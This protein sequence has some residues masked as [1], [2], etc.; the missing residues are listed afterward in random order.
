MHIS[1]ESLHM[2]IKDHWMFWE[3][4]HPEYSGH[5]QTLDIGVYKSKKNLIAY[6]IDATIRQKKQ[7][8]N[9]TLVVNE[10]GSLISDDCDCA[11]FSTG[12]HGC[13]H[14]IAVARAFNELNIDVT[15]LPIH[16]D[17]ESYRQERIREE[18][19]RRMIQQLESN[20]RQAF[21]ITNQ[22]E[23]LKLDRMFS[24]AQTNLYLYVIQKNDTYEGATISLKIGNGQKAYVVKNISTLIRAFQDEATMTF[25]K[26]NVFRLSQDALNEDGKKILDF[27]SRFALVQNWQRNIE[28]NA[29]TIDMY[30]NLL[31]S[32]DPAYYT[33]GLVQEY[34]RFPLSIHKDDGY[35]TIEV[36]EE[37]LESHCDYIYGKNFIY[38][39]YSD[40]IVQEVYDAYGQVS[41]F[42]RAL[43]QEYR[44]TIKEDKFV[45]FYNKTLEPIKEY[46]MFD[47][48]FDLESLAPVISN[49]RVY[50]DLDD[51]QVVIWGRYDQDGEK[52]S[53]FDQT[54]I[55][56]ISMIEKIIEHYA[57][58]VNR[59]EHIAT[60]RTKNQSLMDFLDHGIS[61]IQQESDVF[62]SEDLKKL[63]IRK[64]LNLVVGTRMKNDLLE[65]NIESSVSRDELMAILMA[66][67]KKKN[68][69][70]LKNGEIID[71]SEDSL[72][73]LDRVTEQFNLHKNDLLKEEIEKPAY[74]VLHT[75]NEDGYKKDVTVDEYI[76]H[77]LQ[78]KENRSFELPEKFTSILRPYQIQGVKWMKELKNL[79]LNG[80]LADDM[81]L[82]KT[83]QV[84]CLLECFAKKDKSSIIVCPSSLMF[85]WMSEI[86]KFDID[87]LAICVN[88]NQTQRKE[89]IQ[90]DCDLYITTYD[91]L[92]RDIDVYKKKKFE[93]IIIDEAQF[94][95]N[96]KTQNAKSVKELKGEHKL[97]LTGTPI[98]N[99][100]S[101]L[102]SIFDFLLPG[103]LYSLT[104]FTKNY[105]RPIQLEQA[106]E[107]EERLRQLVL[108]FILR[109]DKN[110]VLSELPDKVEKELWL[111]FN[112][113]EEKLYLANLTQVNEQLAQQLE[114][115][116]VDS[117]VVLAMMTRLRQICC[118]PRMLYDRIQ[119]PSTKL[120]MCVDLIETLKENNKKVLLFSGFTKVFDWLIEEF[121]KKGIKYHLLT[122]QTSKEKRK[123]EIDAFQ[124]DDSDVFLISLKA[125]GT[126][127]N[128][129]AAQAV[130]HFDPW[131]NLSAQNQATDRAY[132]IGQTRNVLVYQ[133]LMKNTI[134]EKIFQMQKRKQAIS[135][136]F[137]Q[138]NNQSIS[139]MSKDELK[140]LFDRE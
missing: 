98:E 14:V 77:L 56:P 128:L 11:E 138:S 54:S 94:I 104:Y 131:W 46:F 80:I 32:I 13:A 72:E 106:E 135:D 130:I 22:L 113:E 122:G 51:S 36:D 53:M 65:I 35:Y 37:S 112:E 40:Q 90:S 136:A 109:R 82:G 17:Y 105:E 64:A 88:G 117:I 18:M 120:A 111:D 27:I 12:K 33:K 31:E 15:H 2:H 41:K 57:S 8:I 52:R 99:S 44:F 133:L 84:L 115:E 67:R 21:E 116:K 9:T 95:K 132:R 78:L 123:E 137:V 59:L 7:L 108:P 23:D 101:E 93:Y 76:D 96:P 91:Y 63:Q 126:G 62:I 73:Q 71:L 4:E 69:Y 1:E 89:L 39:I 79:H 140:D 119:S 102:W 66:Y 34:P 61:L 55:Q 48:D 49:I 16:I 107:K 26:N 83:I 42:A 86:Q 110:E 47:T 43:S 25:G 100:L 81:G 97:A 3:A 29:T 20:T 121:N 60:F 28:L 68:F 114:M 118:E 5:V 103:Y 70:K 74:Q 87:V 129:T 134:E 19:H 10:Y 92:K 45:E 58:D 125:G 6:Q 85:N 75:Q 124:N 139:K 30:A 127:L 38:R 50:A 24:Q